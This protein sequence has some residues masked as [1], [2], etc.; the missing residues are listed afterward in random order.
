MARAI[1]GGFL[2]SI[3]GFRHSH[4]DQRVQADALALRMWLSS[5]AL[6]T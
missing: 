2:L 4:G 1:F 6:P 3:N 5:D